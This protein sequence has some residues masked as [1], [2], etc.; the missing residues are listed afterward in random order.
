MRFFNCLKLKR[1][2]N[3]LENKLS[4]LEDVP[5]GGGNPYYYCPSCQKSIIDISIDSRKKDKIFGHE[6]Q[7]LKA[8][9]IKSLK[10]S[11]KD[12]QKNFTKMIKNQEYNQKS[13]LNF[14][15][16]Q[17]KSSNALKYQADITIIIQEINKTLKENKELKSENFSFY[18]YKEIK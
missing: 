9:L 4:Q 15:F 12:Y 10:T 8:K 5:Y 18:G 7:C 17:L 6:K 2:I 3:Y 1:K 14:I 11:K 16:M 13:V